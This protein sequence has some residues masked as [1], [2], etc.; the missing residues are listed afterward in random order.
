MVCAAVAWTEAES[1][2]GRSTG[3]G[4]SSTQV[5][6]VGQLYSYDHH[7]DDQRNT[8]RRLKTWRLRVIGTE[9]MLDIL[10]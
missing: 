6:V 7:D 2:A 5:D 3:C 10:C 8:G 4:V 1:M 9:L